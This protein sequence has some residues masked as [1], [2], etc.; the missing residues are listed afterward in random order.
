M[1]NITVLKFRTGCQFQKFCLGSK[2]LA[3][4]KFTVI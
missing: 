3:V 1:I 2:K 4:S